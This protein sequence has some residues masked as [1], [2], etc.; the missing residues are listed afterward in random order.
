MAKNGRPTM[1]DV[2]AKAGVSLS[3]V[4]LSYSGAGPISPEMKARVEKAAAALEYGGP[5]AAGR[6]LRSG[7]SHVVGVVIHDSLTLAFRAPLI[8]QIM[9]GLIS[10]LGDMGLGVLLLTSPS[11]VPEENSLLETAPMDAAVL[12]RVR[13]HDEP[14]LEILRKRGIPIVVMDGNPPAGGGVVTIDDGPATVDLIKRLQDLGHERI[15]TVT[16][17]IAP[18]LD[19]S[20]RALEDFEDSAWAPTHRRLLAFKDAGIEPCV[21]VSARESLVEEGIAAGHLALSHE[22]RPTAL[23]VQSDQLAA[24]VLLAARELDIRVPQDLSITGFDGL[25]LPWLAPTELTT[26]VQDGEK[27]GHALA[28]EVKALLA[29]ETPEPAFTPLEFRAGN[30]IGRVNPER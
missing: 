10:D 5:S 9:D 14:A 8:L 25:E 13:D 22:S 17:P 21:I 7:R 18:R 15:G 28:A 26:V 6:A 24:G 4:S 2:A 20:L 27:K 12:L 3:T 19:T 1:A 16:L 11:G 29:G 23:V 30:T